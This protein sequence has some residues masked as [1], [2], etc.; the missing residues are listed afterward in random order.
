MASPVK[1][2]WRA[3]VMIRFVQI[4]VRGKTRRHIPSSGTIRQESAALD[5]A[6]ALRFEEDNLK[7][8]NAVVKANG[9]RPRL[10]AIVILDILSVILK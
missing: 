6:R 4:Y 8:C 9:N 2:V 5:E 3:E 1:L 7:C 10:E